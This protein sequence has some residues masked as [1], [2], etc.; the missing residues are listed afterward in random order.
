M[1]SHSVSWV[2]G[3]HV[4]FGNLD[5]IIMKEGELALV[6]ATV[7]PLHSVGLDAIAEALEE[8]QLHAPEAHILGSD[9]LLGFDY[10]RL[11]RQLGA[12]LGP[13]PSWED[14]GRLTFLFANV[15]TQLA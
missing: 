11:D 7:Q 10:G 9:Q 5:F 12:F 1:A 8:L 4:R 3:V 15:I 14:L 6:P 13:R 2:P